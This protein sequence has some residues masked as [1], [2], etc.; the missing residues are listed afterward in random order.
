MADISIDT[1]LDGIKSGQPV[2]FHDTLDLIAAHYEYRPARFHNGLGD[3]RL[4]NEPGSNEGSCKTFAFARLH[5]LSEPD[6]L[7]LFGEHY[8][9]VLADPDGEGHR[10]IRNF[11][12]HGWAG[13]VFETEPLR[14]RG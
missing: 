12:E 14:P 10:N 11:L 1:F 3:G 8:R 9:E 6:T 13:I 7:A 5:G 2:V 4:I